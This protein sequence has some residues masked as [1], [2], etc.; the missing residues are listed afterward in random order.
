M[1]HIPHIG[2]FGRSGFRHS[3][4]IFGRSGFSDVRGLDI[5]GSFS[6]VRGFLD[7]RGLDI[8][9]SFS[10]IRGF[11]TFGVQIFSVQFLDLWCFR[12]FGVRTFG[13]WT[14]GVRTFGV[15]FTIFGY[16]YEPRTPNPERLKTDVRGSTP[17]VQTPNVQP[18]TSKPRTSKT[19]MSISH[20]HLVWHNCGSPLEIHSQPGEDTDSSPFCS[21]S[22]WV[23]RNPH[24]DHHR[25]MIPNSFAHWAAAKFLKL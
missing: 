18:R 9:G 20:S 2:V 13:V 24:R 23:H 22:L 8:R 19:R 15:F 1:I 7:I 4:F 21:S 5:R 16:W 6:D 12:T 3:G 10:D 14:F 25:H 17:N 11:R